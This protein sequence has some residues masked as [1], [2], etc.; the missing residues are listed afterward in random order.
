MFSNRHGALSQ[1]IAEYVAVKIRGGV[2]NET[3]VTILDDYDGDFLKFDD[4]LTD[5]FAVNKNEIKYI[6]LATADEIQA[7][8]EATA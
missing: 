5:S 3:L 7:I 8:K 6:R 2:E 1:Y 4:R